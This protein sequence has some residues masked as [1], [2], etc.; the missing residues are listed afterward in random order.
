LLSA[1]GDD[2]SSG[3][4]GAGGGDGDGGSG[5]AAPSGPAR[6]VLSSTTF[7]GGDVDCSRSLVNAGTI[8]LTNGGAE[9]L[10]FEMVPGSGWFQFI[11]L[12]A[13]TGTLQAGETTVL[14]VHF[15]LLRAPLLG[16]E[17][18]L[19]PLGEPYT[20]QLVLRTGD[21]TQ[22]EIVLNA[23]V[24]VQGALLH[25]D[26]SVAGDRGCDPGNQPSI[27]FGQATVGTAPQ[28]NV[29]IGV[30]G[31]TAER[32]DAWPQP[33][34]GPFSVAAP[35]SPVSPGTSETIV[36]SFAPVD[37]GFASATIDYAGGAIC[38]PGTVRLSG[39]GVE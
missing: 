17:C 33:V 26:E 38:N 12:E 7:E 8:E 36:L 21:A 19:F 2:E 3:D 24:T 32:I 31:S 20:E 4:G 29:T 18:F 13:P 15:R 22:P 1:C 35:T 11:G 37:P 5:G 9:P 30:S 23:T 10:T 16:P 27:N 28:R 39:T 6:A 34:D 14:G 25:L